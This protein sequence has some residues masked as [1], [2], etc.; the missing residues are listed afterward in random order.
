MLFKR[1]K[2]ISVKRCRKMFLSLKVVVLLK[3]FGLDNFLFYLVENIIVKK[4]ENV[5]LHVVFKN[6][7]FKKNNNNNSK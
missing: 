1:Q 2:Q 5:Y 3:V 4:K 6:K 7:T